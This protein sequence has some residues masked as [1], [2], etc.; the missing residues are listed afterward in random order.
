MPLALR[1]A[2]LTG[3]RPAAVAIVRLWG[4]VP[5]AL[6][7]LGAREVPVG[8][9]ALRAFHDE[10]GAKLD[11]GVVVRLRE[12]LADLMPHGSPLAVSAIEQTLRRA[13]ATE[14][15]LGARDEASL[16][17][18]WPAART[19]VEARMLAALARAQSPRAV[20]LLLEQPARW[21]GADDTRA[22]TARDR[23]LNRLI[24]PPMVVVVGP[25]NVGKSTLLNALA[26]RAVALAADEPGTTRDHVGV[27]IDLGGLVA[28]VVDTPGL[29]E[30]T[31]HVEQRAQQLAL[32][33]IP[34]ADLVLLVGDAQSPPPVVETGGEVLRV[35]LRADLGTPTWAHDLAVRVGAPSTTDDGGLSALA[36]L[37]RERLVT[38]E[39]EASPE[40]WKFW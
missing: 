2:R 16:R 33:L 28:R 39:D 24:D 35:A 25:A 20:G 40:P 10:H 8:A 36:R 18:L 12:D 23:R 27:L 11:A 4:D 38:P 21:T 32:G 30:T 14:L 6:A 37:I 5:G 19:L 22:T 13:G 34:A 29:R 9:W 26:G 1:L 3:P 17:A 31:D 15:D 7:T